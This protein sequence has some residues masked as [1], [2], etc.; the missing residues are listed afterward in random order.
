KSFKG[1][2]SRES[3]QDCLVSQQELKCR[4]GNVDIQLLSHTN[5]LN[6]LT[7]LQL[8]SQDSLQIWGSMS[9]KEIVKQKPSSEL[10]CTTNRA[11]EKRTVI[12]GMCGSEGKHLL[13]CRC[14]L[15]GNNVI[16]Q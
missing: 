8:F 5:G 13:T 2:P 16:D 1:N 7:Y 10:D 3:F 14:G 15:R 6:N 12:V 4:R 9:E 11:T